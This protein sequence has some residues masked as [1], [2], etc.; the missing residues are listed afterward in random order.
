MQAEV[1]NLFFFS[2][3]KVFF[4][5]ARH[6]L[7]NWIT[8]DPTLSPTGDVWHINKSYVKNDWENSPI[9]ILSVS[10]FPQFSGTYRV[11]LK[12]EAMQQS[13]KHDPDFFKTFCWHQIQNE[14]QFSVKMEFHSLKVNMC[15]ANH[16]ILFTLFL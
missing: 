2:T 10:L 8:S 14:V 13:G 1:E 7:L 9:L 3:E 6:I 15:S 5:S 16:R 12:E 4:N 11:L